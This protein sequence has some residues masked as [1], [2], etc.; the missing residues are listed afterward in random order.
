MALARHALALPFFDDESTRRFRRARCARW[1]DAK[2]PALP[3][4]DVDA[5]C[6]ARVQG[7]GRGGLPQGG[8]A[9]VAR[10]AAS[11]AR[12]AHALPR[13]R[14]P[15]VPRRAR[16][17]RLRHAGARHRLDLAVRL[18]RAEA[19]AICRRC[20]TARP[21]RPSRCRSRRPAP[22]SRR[23]PRPPSPTAVHMSGSTAKRPGYRTA[24]SPTI[25]WCSRAPAR[26]RAPRGC[27]PSW[28][29]PT[30]RGSRSPSASR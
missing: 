20:A 27:R 4:D 17:F 16:R 12:R 22:T 25:T 21:S 11:G 23:S 6:R 2:L 7:A 13:P 9:A 26:R 10:R 5:A 14:N 29:M 8:G 15:G 1:A 18:R 30:R 24:E 19:R 28:S 3:H